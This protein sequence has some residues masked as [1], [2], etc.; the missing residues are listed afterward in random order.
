MGAKCWY[1]MHPPARK[2]NAHE[3]DKQD[4]SISET[5]P[6]LIHSTNVLRK[7]VVRP[8]CQ[9]IFKCNNAGYPLKEDAQG[10]YVVLDVERFEALEPERQQI[11]IECRKSIT[12]G[13]SRYTAQKQ[14][15]RNS[16]NPDI[17]AHRLLKDKIMAPKR[18]ETT[19]KNGNYKRADKQAALRNEVAKLKK[20]LCKGKLDEFEEDLCKVAVGISL[21][22]SKA[23]KNRWSAS[24]HSRISHYRSGEGLAFVCSQL[25][26]IIIIIKIK[27][28]TLLPPFP[29]PALPCPALPCPEIFTSLITRLKAIFVFNDLFTAYSGKEGALAPC[30]ATQ[31]LSEHCSDIDIGSP[32]G[33]GIAYRGRGMQSPARWSQMEP[34][35]AR[36][37]HDTCALETPCHGLSSA[38]VPS[39]TGMRCSPCYPNPHVSYR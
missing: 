11:I 12:A 33:S 29:C 16:V 13:N 17:K 28:W 5:K 24:K 19:Q 27:P 25:T 8:S 7:Y 15:Q 21:T 23:I 31:L 9:K 38:G 3:T 10:R 26:I 2:V 32:A 4:G 34:D 36:W 18:K 35:G 6:P 22:R 1:E 37:S 39:G 20:F 30:N 14:D